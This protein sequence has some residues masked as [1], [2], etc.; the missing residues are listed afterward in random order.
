MKNNMKKYNLRVLTNDSYYD[1]TVEAE[2]M[3]YGN[4]GSY[5]FHNGGLRG[6][7]IGK[8]VAS[9][10]IGRTIIVSVEEPKEIE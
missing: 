2:Q 7:T 6:Y 1:V 3:T 8:V 10:P 4:H 5:L 9:Y